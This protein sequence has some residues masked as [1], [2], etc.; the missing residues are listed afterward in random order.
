MITA[1]QRRK[2]EGVRAAG[3]EL[4]CHMRQKSE[5]DK[6]LSLNGHLNVG[7]GDNDIKHG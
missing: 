5:W 4:A 1:S 6:S 3:E 7:H 2:R